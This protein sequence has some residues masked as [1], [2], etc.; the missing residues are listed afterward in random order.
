MQHSEF[1]IVLSGSLVTINPKQLVK[2][3]SK[4]ID[5]YEH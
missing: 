5:C 2:I 4:K 1:K 3:K